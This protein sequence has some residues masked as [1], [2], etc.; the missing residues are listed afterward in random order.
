MVITSV[1]VSL[2][3]NV[4]LKREQLRRLDALGMP[5]L[6]E[7]DKLRKRCE[8]EAFLLPLAPEVAANLADAEARGVAEKLE[9][10][11]SSLWASQ[12]HWYAADKGRRKR[13]YSPAE[14]A[15]LS[16]LDI[17]PRDGISLLYSQTAKGAFCAAVLEKL[18]K[19][20][21]AVPA[22]VEVRKELI[23]GLQVEDLERFTNEGMVNYVR[24]VERIRAAQ[25]EDVSVL[26][27]I[28]GGYK[29]LTPIATIAAMALD[30]EVCY[31]YEDSDELLF[32]PALDVGFEFSRLFAR[33]PDLMAR[34]TPP[35]TPLPTVP[36]DQFEERVVEEHRNAFEK[37]VNQV[38]EGVQLSP[39]GVLAWVL[40]TRRGGIP[41]APPRG[42]WEQ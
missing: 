22:D 2:L 15:S 7:V 35:A 29:G 20:G 27:N 23:E 16:L 32:L 34:F 9:R 42:P 38:D 12:E 11:L 18:L 14:L 33:Y 31:L 3:E 40:H 8:G 13:E 41:E 30:V 36:E 28:T 4:L 1:G 26:L 24:A 10:A 6:D 25:S 37:Y 39:L 21:V 19:Q 5:S 17:Q